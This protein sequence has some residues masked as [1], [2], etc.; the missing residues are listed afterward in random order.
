MAFYVPSLCVLLPRSRRQVGE[1]AHRKLFMY[2]LCVFFYPEVEGKLVKEHTES[3][4]C[5]LCVLFYPEPKASW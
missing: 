4:L 2:L 5:T 3:F 1:R